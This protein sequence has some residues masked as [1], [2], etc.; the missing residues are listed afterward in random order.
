LIVGQVFAVVLTL[1]AQILL[2]RHLSKSGY[3]VFAFG[4]SVVQVAE[5][6]AAFGLR[7]GVNRFLPMYEERDEPELAAGLLVFAVTTVLGLGVTVACVVIGFRGLIGGAVAGATGAATVLAILI[8]LAPVHAMEN[9][10]DGVFAVFARPRT[11]VLRK[12]VYIPAM[13][14]A[15]VAAVSVTG[16]SAR[17]LAWGWVSAGVLGLVAYGTLLAQV[18]DQRGL[19]TRI[20]VLDVRYPVR[21]LLRFTI[22]LLTSDITAVLFASVGTILLGYMASAAEVATLRAVLPIATTMTYVIANFELLFVPL[23]SRLLAQREGPQISRL[24][25]QTTAWTAVLSLPIF[26]PSFVFA[27]PLTAFLFGERYADSAAVLAVLAAG[28]Y[29][30]AATG[31]NGLLLGVY[32]DVRFIAA[33][34]ALVTACLV[35]LNILLIPGHGALGAAIASTVSVILLNAAFQWRLMTRTDVRGVDRAYAMLLGAIAVAVAA[36]TTLQVAISPPLWIG[37]AAAIAAFAVIAVL[38][39]RKLALAESFPELA[40]VP[41]LRRLV[42]TGDPP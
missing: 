36:L 22:P 20:R 26:L 37:A 30:I 21:E 23:A 2:V 25:W 32:G 31:L 38:A 5:I 1:A 8:L 24:Y 41:L 15:V 9:L 14:L 16:A 34:N 28:Y 27:G 10:L 33:T 19:L 3:G 7:R 11:I 35:G 6:V 42:A 4:L 13:R 40:H 39:R 12:H 17:V 18:L 29:A